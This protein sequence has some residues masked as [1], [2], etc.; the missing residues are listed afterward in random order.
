MRFLAMEAPVPLGN[1]QAEL[2]W[3]KTGAQPLPMVSLKFSL[4]T[5]VDALA[6]LSREAA[7]QNKVQKADETDNSSLFAHAPWGNFPSMISQSQDQPAVEQSCNKVLRRPPEIE[8]QKSEPN[9]AHSGEF[10][11]E[12][13]HLYQTGHNISVV[14]P[15]AVALADSSD[16]LLGILGVV[17][18]PH[19]DFDW[20]PPAGVSTGEATQ[21]PLQKY[22]Q[23]EFGDPLALKDFEASAHTEF[24][25]TTRGSV[26]AGNFVV[27]RDVP[28]D[29]VINGSARQVSSNSNGSARQ[30][31]IAAGDELLN[32]L[33]HDYPK[34]QP[35]D[36]TAVPDD[37]DTVDS[38]D[39]LTQVDV[40]DGSADA[41]HDVV[42]QT[43]TKVVVKAEFISDGKD[44]I[45]LQQGL[46]G[47]VKRMDD[48]GD[49]L[50]S[51]GLGTA[52][53]VKR[54]NFD[55][56]RLDVGD[57]PELPRGCWVLDVDVRQLRQ[58][59]NPAAIT[60]KPK[61]GIDTRL[62]QLLGEWRS[63]E[64]DRFEVTEGSSV[65]YLTV[66]IRRKDGEVTTR[67]NCIQIQKYTGKILYGQ[68]YELTKQSPESV[69]WHGVNRDYIW[70][71]EK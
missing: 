51:F 50:I 21:T 1:A 53:W 56:L 48:N 24:H 67:K 10:N 46:R 35:D 57:S 55:K 33:T 7:T 19:E 16:A 4:S 8:S 34:I 42:L 3:D 29:V 65:Y 63:G 61:E 68:G 43:G 66:A 13:G 60:S 25:S 41:I 71:K 69:Y 38:R 44:K 64:S 49:A 12:E 36:D 52:T 15:T 39:T 6:R 14:Q 23:E 31:D 45:Q 58:G 9:S 30:V 26:V 18:E 17:R 22:M 47:S 70:N 37:V 11:H 27:A 54:R 62:L 20:T 28:E 59:L 5:L 2:C 40:V 32:I